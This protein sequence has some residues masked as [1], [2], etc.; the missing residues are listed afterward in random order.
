MRRGRS[1]AFRLLYLP[2]LGFV[3]AVI[4]GAF[5]DFFTEEFGVS[6]WMTYVSTLAEVLGILS[7]VILFICIPIALYF[8]FFGKD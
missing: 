8:F 6:T 4:F 7:L 2:L 3:I 5:A 1:I